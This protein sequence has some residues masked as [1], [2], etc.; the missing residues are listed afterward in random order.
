MKSM[1]LGKMASSIQRQKGL[2][3]IEVLVVLAVLAAVIGA[4]YGG[5]R[6]A[7]SDVAANELGRAATSLV[8]QIKRTL[9]STGSYADVSVTTIGN[10]GL[11][12]S[13]W[14]IVGANLNDNFGNAVTINGSAGSFALAF[15]S[16]S[17]ADCAKVLPLLSGL[18]YRATVGDDAAAA[19]GAATG[20]SV[21]KA[22]D[23]TITPSVLNSGCSAEDRILALEFR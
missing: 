12:P 15:P 21:Y 16:L 6:A 18:A 3:M 14:K 5:S 20:A 9:G 17:S 11:V 23:G 1:K 2:T 10:L 4:V 7:N 13:S 22:G 19:S 8:S